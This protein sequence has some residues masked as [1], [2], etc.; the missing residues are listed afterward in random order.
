MIS[1]SI[2]PGGNPTALSHPDRFSTA[3]QRCPDCGAWYCDECLEL[4]P[5]CPDCP[6]PATRE[7]QVQRIERML[8]SDAP[9]H[10]VLQ[11]L[12][13]FASSHLP[14]GPGIEDRIQFL[15]ES[16]PPQVLTRLIEVAQFDASQFPVGEHPGLFKGNEEAIP[17]PPDA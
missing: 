5:M 2:I 8:A 15:R 12:W 16:L 6:G 10:H 1:V 9:A 11:T 13:N 3:Y 14:A 4:E 17:H 7:E